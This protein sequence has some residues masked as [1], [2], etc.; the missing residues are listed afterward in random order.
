MLIYNVY[1]YCN[2][3]HSTCQHV[4][5][6]NCVKLLIYLLE[7]LKADP[8]ALHIG[9][10]TL[11]EPILLWQY[12]PWQPAGYN[13][14]PGPVTML[15]LSEQCP[16]LSPHFQPLSGSIIQLK[17]WLCGLDNTDRSPYIQPAFDLSPL[18]SRQKHTTYLF[19]PAHE[20]TIAGCPSE[21]KV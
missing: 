17:D 19:T 15:Q 3:H 8:S 20:H 5:C 14:T 21:V 10:D 2:V 12:F 16:G 9:V 18:K 6:V 7:N 13:C 1:V 4:S 11:Q